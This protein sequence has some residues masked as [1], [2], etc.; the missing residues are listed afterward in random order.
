M[1]CIVIEMTKPFGRKLESLSI[2]FL[3]QQ[4]SDRRSEKGFAKPWM[5]NQ[6]RCVRCLILHRNT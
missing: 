1:F 3:V 4:F 5:A 2:S 6:I